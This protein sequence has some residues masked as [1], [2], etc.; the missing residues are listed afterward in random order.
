[1]WVG[2]SGCDQWACNITQ[3]ESK[4]DIAA[5]AQRSWAAF[6]IRNM[7]WGQGDFC[8]TEPRYGGRL[9]REPVGSVLVDD[10]AFGMHDDCIIDFMR[11]LSW[12][13]CGFNTKQRCSRDAVENIRQLHSCHVHIFRDYILGW[14]ASTNSTSCGRRERVL[15]H[16]LPTLCC[17]RCV[18][19]AAAYHSASRHEAASAYA[20]LR[21]LSVMTIIVISTIQRHTNHH[22]YHGCRRRHPHNRHH[23]H[24]PRPPPPFPLDHHDPH[25]HVISK[26]WSHM[27]CRIANA[28]QL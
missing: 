15:C 20:T 22:H 9:S 5:I 7:S 24:R 13:Y 16:T 21:S 3:I 4:T 28:L 11:G 19:G 8:R 27:W 1:M 6:R 17:G 26:H 12:L 2:Q 14:M 10:D 25:G 23:G 18:C